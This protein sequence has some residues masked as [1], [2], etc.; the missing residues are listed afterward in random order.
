[1]QSYTVQLLWLLTNSVIKFEALKEQMNGHWGIQGSRAVRVCKLALKVQRNMLIITRCQMRIQ[2]SRL[3]DSVIS[4]LDIWTAV[5]NRWVG[6]EPLTNS[7]SAGFCNDKFDACNQ[8]HHSAKK[9]SRQQDRQCLLRL[10]PKF[11]QSDNSRCCHTY[12]DWG[13]WD[14]LILQ[15][16]YTQR[17]HGQQQ[18]RFCQKIWQ[19]KQKKKL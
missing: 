19:Q 18:H 2:S 17:C 14:C 8:I 16:F 7:T 4:G 10:S 11:L 3:S 5:R 13:R 12:L 6:S 1:M 9:C 15:N